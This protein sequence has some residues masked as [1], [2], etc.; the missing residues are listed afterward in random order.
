MFSTSNVTVV[1]SKL[2]VPSIQYRL[3][4][5]MAK[6]YIYQTN[7]TKLH[8][9]AH[10]IPFSGYNRVMLVKLM[11]T[12]WTLQIFPILF[13][14]PSSVLYLRREADRC[15]RVRRMQYMKYDLTYDNDSFNIYRTN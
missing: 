12:G 14:A 9:L 11:H 6:C 3:V 10:D 4:T 2:N 1:I 13:N 5:K 7:V 8:I 15:K